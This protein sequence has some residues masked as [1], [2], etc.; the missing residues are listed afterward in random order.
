[1]GHSTWSWMWP[2]SGLI[3]DVQKRRNRIEKPE[4]CAARRTF[5]QESA[6]FQVSL[7][8]VPRLFLIIAEG[9]VRAWFTRRGEPRGWR[10]KAH[11]RATQNLTPVVR[12]IQVERS[13]YGCSPN[14]DDGR[15]SGNAR[16]NRSLGRQARRHKNGRRRRGGFLP[17]PPG[18]QWIHRSGEGRR[19]HPFPLQR[20]QHAV[21]LS[22]PDPGSCSVLADHSGNPALRRPVTRCS[23]S[24]DRLKYLAVSDWLILYQGSIRSA[25]STTG[26]AL[27][28][29]PSFA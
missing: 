10:D 12:E 7:R 28:S 8:T 9:S 20:D 15:D 1:M 26:L 24:S 2:Q 6:N 21:V 25:F 11:C 22:G 17:C 4:L 3:T 5:S 14:H 13:D 29:S 19:P 16:E 18:S 27:S 23:V